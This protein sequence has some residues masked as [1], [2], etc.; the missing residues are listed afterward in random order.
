MPEEEPTFESQDK[1]IN[2]GGVE[3]APKIELS[4]EQEQV[5]DQKREQLLQGDDLCLRFVYHKE[6]QDLIERGETNNTNE[7]IMEKIANLP[8]QHGGG[9]SSDSA[10]LAREY[11]R[12]VPGDV[13][14]AWAEIADAMTNWHDSSGA[15]ASEDRFFNQYREFYEQCKSQGLGRAEARTMFA[16]YLK[17]RALDFVLS[18]YG[19]AK[20]HQKSSMEVKIQSAADLL[21]E[22]NENF[23]DEDRAKL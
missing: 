11:N 1:E 12:P 6:Y 8:L 7:C 9:W 2:I 4:L 17:D 22:T 21:P 18:G 20:E 3:G 14:V 13:N 23:P 10:I 5:L 16:D 15:L 19:A